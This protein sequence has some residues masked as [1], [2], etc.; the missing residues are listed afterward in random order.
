MSR[1]LPIRVYDYYAPGI[2]LLIFLR[3][4]LLILKL[5]YRTIQRDDFRFFANIF[6]KYLRSVRQFTMSVLYH[7]QRRIQVSDS[8]TT[9]HHGTGCC[10]S[11]KFQ[12]NKSLQFN[13][14]L[15]STVEYII[16][17]QPINQQG[18]FIECYDFLICFYFLIF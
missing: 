2:K 12:N 3:K 17:M 9:Y 4:K 6:A 7:L 5:L 15:Y 11:T 16:Y 1:Y 13:H 18:N 10:V 8:I 14:Q